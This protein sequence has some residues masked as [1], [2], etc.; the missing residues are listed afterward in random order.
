MKSVLLCVLALFVLLLASCQPTEPDSTSDDKAEPEN[1]ED[2]FGADLLALDEYDVYADGE[3]VLCI[4]DQPDAEVS[5]DSPEDVGLE[6]YTLQTK[7]GIEIGSTLAQLAA[8]YKGM[9]ALLLSQPDDLVPLDERLLDDPSL[10]KSKVLLVSYQ[11]VFVA[12]VPMSLLD[13]HHVLEQRGI[14]TL[15]YIDE[16]VFGDSE[17]NIPMIVFGIHEGKVAAITIMIT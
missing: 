14:D 5:F 4:T 13:F 8:A 10:A 1:T 15:D 6:G 3:M 9:P 7:R 16:N 2:E 17:I 12:T 11:T